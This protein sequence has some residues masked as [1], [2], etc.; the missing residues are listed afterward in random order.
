[1]RE[2]LSARKFLRII[3]YD[4]AVLTL[5]PYRTHSSFT[6]P[7]NRVWKLLGRWVSS[8]LRWGCPFLLW[9]QV[10]IGQFF[11]RYVR[12]HVHFLCETAGKIRGKMKFIKKIFTYQSESQTM[13]IILQGSSLSRLF[14]MVEDFRNICFEG[15]RLFLAVASWLQKRWGFLGIN[16]FSFDM[17]LTS[18]LIDLLLRTTICERAKCTRLCLC[19]CPHQPIQ[20]GPGA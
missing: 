20:L 13:V 5:V 9:F 10:L 17:N 19:L 12:K 18:S 8:V 11:H 16:H 4:D 7:I 15:W 6:S 3:R 2:N 1:M 14:D